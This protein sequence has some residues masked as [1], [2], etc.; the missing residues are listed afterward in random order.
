MVNFYRARNKITMESVFVCESREGRVGIRA[1]RV[2]CCSFPDGLVTKT[3]E[4]C[5]Q[6]EA[7]DRKSM[8]I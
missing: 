5:E 4:R 2:T 8:E 6:F 3:C 7:D 1:G